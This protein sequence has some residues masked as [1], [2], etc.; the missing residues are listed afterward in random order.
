MILAQ[1]IQ[2]VLP[3]EDDAREA[4]F[5][6]DN[7]PVEASLYEADDKRFY[8]AWEAIQDFKDTHM[9]IH[10]HPVVLEHR[11]NWEARVAEYEA[12]SKPQLTI[13]MKKSKHKLS[14]SDRLDFQVRRLIA[15]TLKLQEAS[16]KMSSKNPS[17]EADTSTTNQEAQ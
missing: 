7:P 15:N 17:Q 14:D 3:G 4:K 10:I 5:V 13:K 1:T 9:P 8:I 16:R 12:A 2:V 11:R 6:S